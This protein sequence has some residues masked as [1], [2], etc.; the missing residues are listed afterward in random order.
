MPRLRVGGL[1][2]WDSAL[3]AQLEP[4]GESGRF[5]RVGSAFQFASPPMPRLRVGGL[6]EW[7]SALHAQLNSNDESGRFTRVGS[8]FSLDGASRKGKKE[9]RIT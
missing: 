1:L 8:S 4:L 2:E 6:L 7:D 3:H 9:K 5:I